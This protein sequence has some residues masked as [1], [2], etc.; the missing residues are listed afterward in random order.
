MR[1][2]IPEEPTRRGSHTSACIVDKA[3]RSSVANAM[4]DER[5]AEPE[6]RAGSMRGGD[7]EEGE[8]D[9]GE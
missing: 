6:P 3:T 7:L 1:H 4:E 5:A 2:E 9:A 8:C